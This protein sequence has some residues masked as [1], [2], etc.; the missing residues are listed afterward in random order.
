MTKEE[1]YRAVHA[2][3]NARGGNA[4]RYDLEAMQHYADQETESLRQQNAKLVE[5]LKAAAQ[6]LLPFH[7]AVNSD[8][9]KQINEA[10]QQ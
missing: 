1:I 6:A 7:P 8:V 10:L 2:K 9:F 3:Y 5:A 4:D